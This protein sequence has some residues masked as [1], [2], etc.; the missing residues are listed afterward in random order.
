MEPWFNWVQ[1]P[2][3]SICR[4]FS[5]RFKPWARARHRIV[6][7]PP[8]ELMT[9]LNCESFLIVLDRREH[10]ADKVLDKAKETRSSTTMLNRY[11]CSKKQRTTHK[12]AWIKIMCGL[13]WMLSFSWAFSSAW[14]RTRKRQ[15]LSIALCSQRWLVV[16]SLRTKT[17][18]CQYFSWPIWRPF[19]SLC[20]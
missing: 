18:V 8:G 9:I 15:P 4:T 7:I 13:A 19:W 11:K 10:W 6:S 14:A 3:Q 20:R 5:H 1:I 17:F 16:S 12:S 2:L